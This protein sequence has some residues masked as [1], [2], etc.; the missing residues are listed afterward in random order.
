[1]VSYK[2]IQVFFLMQLWMTG[3]CVCVCCTF[4]TPKY[5]FT[6]KRTIFLESYILAGPRSFTS[7]GDCLD[8]FRVKMWFSGRVRVG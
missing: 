8:C 1:M 7:A 5:L 3:V 6:G 4:Y 2:D